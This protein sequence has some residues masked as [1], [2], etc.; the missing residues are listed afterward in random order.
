MEPSFFNSLG[1]CKGPAKKST[2]VKPGDS[3]PI[4]EFTFTD[5]LTFSRRATPS[6]RVAP[7]CSAVQFEVDF[8]P[9]ARGMQRHLSALEADFLW[10][11]SAVY[12]ADR[13]ALRYPYGKGGPSHWRRRIH[14][15]LP[16]IEASHW[17]FVEAPLVRALEFLTE[18]DWTFEFRSGRTEF[19]AELQKHFPDIHPP[20][21]NWTSL[22]SGG[23]DSLAGALRWF[24]KTEGVGQLVS[25]Q[26]HHRMAVGQNTQAAHLRESFAGRVEHVNF[27]YGF[28]D[29]QC[30]G[31]IGLDSSQRTR[32]FVHT[33]LGALAALR[34]G[35]SELLLFENGVGA[36]NL[37]CD[38][39]QIGS[40]NSRGTHPLFLNRMAQFVSDAFSQRF[41][42][43][44]PFWLMTKAQML[45]GDSVQ[46]H[47]FLLDHS[48]SCDRFPNYKHRETQCGCCPS[49]LI[50]R[51]A[52]HGAGLSENP[53]NYS[54]D[55][56]KFQ[57]PLCDAEIQSIYKL[58]IQAGT[59]AACMEEKD[60]WI[61]LCAVWPDML[62]A[63]LELGFDAERLAI[64]KLFARHVEEWKSF[65]QSFDSNI[66][67]LAA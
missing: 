50:R 49:C 44:N 34:A 39:S 38:S 62:R 21:V 22:F 19:A 33:A 58:N 10:L 40:M 1:N 9:I 26:T 61:A 36:L 20:E 48:F 25:G 52:F 6:L 37:P 18:D 11:A 47:S 56:L 2:R 27:C 5:N 35:N 66:L 67:A 53:K 7:D 28:T 45:L 30:S 60:P 12:F 14:V 13:S 32:A 42:I 63:E 17:S 51:L 46:Q 55:V 4:F 57:R 31:L 59:L 3:R 43:S 23:L 15:T 65:S 54:T 16:M 64:V 41:S 29:K 24:F 8:A